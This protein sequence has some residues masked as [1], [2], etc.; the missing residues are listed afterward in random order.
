MQYIDYFRLKNKDRKIACLI[1]S[2]I[3]LLCLFFHSVLVKRLPIYDEVF[4]MQE[5]KLLQTFG[6]SIPFL[7]GSKT[8]TG[9]L[10]AIVH[11]L[12][13]PLTYL[14]A[15]GIRLVNC[16]LLVLLI[17]V[18]VFT[19]YLLKSKSPW[20]SGFT[21]IATPMIWVVSGMALTEIPAMFFASGG[22]LLLL[23]SVDDRVNHKSSRVLLAALGGL[24]YSFSILGRQ[25]FIV[26]LLALPLL[27]VRNRRNWVNILVFFTASIVL[28][29]IVF[30]IWGGIVPPSH[31]RS[32]YIPVGGL[33]INYGL[34]SYS[35]T[36]SVFL[37]YAPKWF[38]LKLKTSIGVIA[39]TVISNFIFGYI[40]IT[41]AYSVVHNILPEFMVTLYSK[42]VS[43]ILASFGVL[44][45]LA[46]AK[47]FWKN[48]HDPVFAFLCLSMFLVCSTPFKIIH[49]FSSRYVATAVPLILLVADRYSKDTYWK[50][51]RMAIGTVLGFFLLRSYFLAN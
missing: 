26:V 18:L 23:L 39:V 5:V 29:A 40:N 38:S 14:E 42:V 1:L 46:T 34:L 32:N 11:Y 21:I 41:P 13:Q 30:Y 6:L 22:I 28:P 48:R 35:Y 47:N 36:A 12:L 4:Y 3:G 8:A 45:F 9:P 16:F 20:V 24:A 25:T 44:F 19:F 51:V 43:S 2:G 49:L 50:A 31:Q 10:V 33:S 37:I 27:A 15:P 17:V 7:E